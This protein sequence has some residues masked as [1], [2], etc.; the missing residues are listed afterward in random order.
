MRFEVRTPTEDSHVGPTKNHKR[1]FYLKVFY[2][3]D[4]MSAFLLE[5][6]VA[7]EIGNRIHESEP[8]L[9]MRIQI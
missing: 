3:E 7:E 6:N 1:K 4:S 5:Y 8:T 2:A 9:C